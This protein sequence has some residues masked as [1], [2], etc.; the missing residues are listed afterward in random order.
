MTLE[1]S[2]T[3]VSVDPL[4]AA[5][6]AL[7]EFPSLTP[8]AREQ[9]RAEIIQLCVPWARREAARYRHSGE[10]LE[11]LVQVALVGLILAVDRYDASRRVPFRHFAQPTVTGE[12]KRYFRD[13]GWS[14]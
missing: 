13:R 3:E 10:P 8:L 2:S 6:Q 9:R 1:Q 4:A 5:E 14:M 7:Q 11:D 12:I